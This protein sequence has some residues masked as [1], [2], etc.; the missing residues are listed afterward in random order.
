MTEKNVLPVIV[1]GVCNGKDFE[2]G[3][4]FELKKSGAFKYGNELMMIVH[5]PKWGKSTLLMSVM[6]RRKTWRS[7]RTRG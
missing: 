6:R 3:I 2:E 1:S 5:R 7:S 4:V